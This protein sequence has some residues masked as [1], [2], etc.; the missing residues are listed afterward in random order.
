[1]KYAN[2][3]AFCGEFIE[4]AKHGQGILTIAPSKTKDEKPEGS[5]IILEGGNEEEKVLE[6]K[7]GE[8]TGDF[9]ND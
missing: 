7:G 8:Y 4:G 6:E 5:K 2:G 1:M 3:D 9:E